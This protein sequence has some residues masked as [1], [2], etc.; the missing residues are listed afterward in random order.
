MFSG[1]AGVDVLSLAPGA[2]ARNPDFRVPD[3][4]VLQ[5][6]RDGNFAR[7]WKVGDTAAALADEVQMIFRAGIVPRTRKNIQPP[8]QSRGGKFV[9]NAVNAFPRHRRQ[10][11][12]DGVQRFV[13]AGMRA[14]IL[15]KAVDFPPLRGAFPTVFPAERRKVFPCFFHCPDKFLCKFILHA[16]NFNSYFEI[17][18]P[19]FA[20]FPENIC[21]QDFSLE[22]KGFR[23]Y[24]KKRV[25]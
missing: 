8:E 12:A 4:P 10:M 14:V 11:S 20:F 15:Q 1:I 22:K 3:F 13:H 2:N 18:K 19:F 24:F 7:D 25:F 6:R 17:C 23:M 5:F 9:Q 21:G 16:N